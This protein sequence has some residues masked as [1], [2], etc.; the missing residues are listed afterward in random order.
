MLNLD[1]LRNVNANR[2]GQTAIAA[3]SGLETFSP[4]EQVAGLSLVFLAALER[5]GV[6]ASVAFDVATNLFIRA[7]GEQEIRALRAYAK[8]EW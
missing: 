8:G 5:T 1:Q 3:L 4:A 7:R 2:A 6:H